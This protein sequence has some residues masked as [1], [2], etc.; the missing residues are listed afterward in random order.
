M[1]V[2]NAAD[3]NLISEISS[4]I[5][6][7]PVNSGVTSVFHETGFMKTKT[8]EKKRDQFAAVTSGLLRSRKLNKNYK[9]LL[10]KMISQI[11]TKYS[12]KY[13]MIRLT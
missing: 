13:K 1:V 8:V 10:S 7:V 4:I 9:L 3:R 2:R 12:L 5:V 6:K 11:L